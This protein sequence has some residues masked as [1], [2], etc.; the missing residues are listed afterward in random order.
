MVLDRLTT[1]LVCLLYAKETRNSGLWWLAG[2]TLAAGGVLAAA[3][4]AP[5][6]AGPIP[7]SHSQPA[8]VELSAQVRPDPG[9][10]TKAQPAFTAAFSTLAMANIHAGGLVPAAPFIFRGHGNDRDRALDCLAAAA[11]YE[12]GDDAAGERA[13][14]QVVLNRLKHP[15]FPKSVCAVVFEGSNRATGCQFTF[16]CDGSM[17]RRAPS[18]GAWTRA[19]LFAQAAL[20]GAVDATVQQATH[21]HADYVSPWWSGAME[22]LA[23]V[24]AHIFYRWPG[25]RGALLGSP[26][27]APEP[28]KV[29]LADLG[30]R[31]PVR[32]DTSSRTGAGAPYIAPSMDIFDR[33]A[34]S[35]SVQGT[36]TRPGQTIFLQVDVQ[37]PSGRWAVDALGKCA[38]RVAC[39]VVAYGSPAQLDRNRNAAGGDRERPAFLFVRD[40]VSKMDLA[41]WDCD[42]VQRP[43]ASQCLPSSGAELKRLMRDTTS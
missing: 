16:T 29:T 20:S 10:F 18:A 34:G 13:V 6:K 9:V 11:W 32:S 33:K 36:I 17:Q 23:K 28:A 24:G 26:G 41:L 37:G 12:A 21:Y 5:G 25:G 38:G 19:R 40:P 8:S 22:P 1:Q 3:A 2:L 30:R 39:Q 43:S 7:E 4:S 27:L 42:E 31:E 35:A 14:I 15:S